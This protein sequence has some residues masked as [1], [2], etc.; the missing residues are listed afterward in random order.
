M[1]KN[2]IYLKCK[3]CGEEFNY[4]VELQKHLRSYHKLSPKT[5]FETYWKRIDRFDGKK[6]EYKSFDQYITCD[7]VDKKNYKN[8]LK[9]LSQE[10][11]ADYFK[12]KLDQYCDLKNL[13]VAPGQVECQSINCLLP[14]STIETFSGT[15]YNDL[16]KKIG[17]HSRFNY[18]ILD[19]IPLT[20]IPQIIVDSREQKPFHFEGHTLIE[21]KLEY[22]DYSLHPNNK[23]AVERKSLSDLYGT[24]SGGKERFEREI[25]KAK[26]LEGYIVVMVESTLNNMMYQKQKFGKAS[27]EFIAH[28]MRQLLRKYDNLQFVF[29]DGREEARDKTLNILEMDNQVFGIDLQYYFYT[30]CL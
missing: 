8:W 25:Q 11:C 27:G 1:N 30:K 6:I 7:F 9:T 19:Q 18:K 22:G 29:C 26:K 4:F 16:C 10:E 23:L 5:Y 3:V 12:N 21:S 20:P 17:L 14:V 2:K 13:D 15:S 28:N 24:L